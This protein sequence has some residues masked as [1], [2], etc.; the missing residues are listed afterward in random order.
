MTTLGNVYLLLVFGSWGIR[1][2]TLLYGDWIYTISVRRNA[3]CL[4]KKH[5]YLD[6]Q[7]FVYFFNISQQPSMQSA[8][9]V[10]G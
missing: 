8:E 10:G 5:T 3:V 9:P 6:R 2:P 7:H 4:L 1:G